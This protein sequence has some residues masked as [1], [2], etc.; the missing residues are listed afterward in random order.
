MRLNPEYTMTGSS[1]H[2]T[3]TIKTTNPAASSKNPR[4]P[5]AMIPPGN[6]ERLAMAMPIA[7]TMK[8]NRATMPMSFHGTFLFTEVFFVFASLATT[9]R[10]HIGQTTFVPFNSAG[11]STV[12]SQAGHSILKTASLIV[13]SGLQPKWKGRELVT[14]TRGTAKR[15]ERDTI[16]RAQVGRLT[17]SVLSLKIR[18]FLAIR[19][20][21]ANL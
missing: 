10:A 2:I 7:T 1:A 13:F 20:G 19:T 21:Y 3:A 17:E 14:P 8:M 6:F 4:I 18:G 5:P 12:A 9:S 11:H 15:L 16:S